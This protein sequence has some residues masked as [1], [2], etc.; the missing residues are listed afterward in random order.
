MKYKNKYI[1]KNKGYMTSPK[2]HNI[3]DSKDNEVNKMPKDTKE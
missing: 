1:N 3:S 2:G